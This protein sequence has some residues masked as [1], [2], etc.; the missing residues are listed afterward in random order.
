MRFL[1]L[2]FLIVF[3]SHVVAQQKSSIKSI[4]FSKVSRGYE[5]RVNIT[6]DS[7]HIWIDD[8]RSGR[9][10]VTEKKQVTADDWTS[11]LSTANGIDLKQFS[12]LPSPT[13]K[14]AVDAA[15]HSTITIVTTDGLSYSHGFDDENPHVQGLPLLK[16]ITAI[17]R[18][19][20]R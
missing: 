15:M 1:S 18:I 14:R 19:D 9:I 20:K 6:S 4:E 10:P 16:K 2:L 13:M 11:L 5:Q 12:S 7:L 8:H 17:S 3:L